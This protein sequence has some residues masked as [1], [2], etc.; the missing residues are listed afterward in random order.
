VPGAGGSS[1]AAWP[2]GQPDSRFLSGPPSAAYGAEAP[3]PRP[4]DD[5]RGRTAPSP[6]GSSHDD[7]PGG[8]ADPRQ[9]YPGQHAAPR[10]PS[11]TPYGDRDRRDAGRGQPSGRGRAQ[12]Q[13]TSGWTEADQSPAWR[14]ESRPSGWPESGRQPSWPQGQPG[15]H[16]ADD[17]DA[18]VSRQGPARPVPDQVGWPEQGESLEALPPIAG[19]HHDWDGS[20]DQARRGWLTPDDETDGDT[21]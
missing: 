14:P 13:P 7:F 3:P 10:S 2:A 8:A 15:A 1:R 17:A 5:R 4:R 21:W 9:R 12:P 18:P 16:R 20:P 19:G 6:S 11:G